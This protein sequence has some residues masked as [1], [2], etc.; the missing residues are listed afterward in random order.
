LSELARTERLRYVGLEEGG[1]NCVDD[2]QI[3]QQVQAHIEE[4]LA[5]D[6]LLS[7]V[8]RDVVTDARVQQ[9]ELMDTSC[10]QL[11]EVRHVHLLDV[12]IEDELLREVRRL[13]GNRDVRQDLPS[14]DHSATAA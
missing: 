7:I 9:S 6:R 10:T 5:V 11:E 3:S 4:V 1:V 8:V 2:L 14:C 13:R 12:T